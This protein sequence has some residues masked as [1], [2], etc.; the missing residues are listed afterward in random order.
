MDRVQEIPLSQSV[1]DNDMSSFRLEAGGRRGE[2][3]HSES[4]DSCFSRD[5]NREKN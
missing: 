3:W 1:G 2:S 5:L 4:K